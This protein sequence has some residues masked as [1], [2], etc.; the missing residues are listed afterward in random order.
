MS[1]TQA[2]FTRFAGH[3]E[4]LDR[5]VSNGAELDTGKITAREV[6][7]W[8]MPNSFLGAIEAAWLKLQRAPRAQLIGT[9]LSLPEQWEDGSEPSSLERML[10]AILNATVQPVDIGPGIPRFARS[11]RDIDVCAKADLRFARLLHAMREPKKAAGE[12]DYQIIVGEEGVVGL[13]KSDTIAST[14]LLA[15][16]AICGT[17][18]TPAI[19]TGAGTLVAA[20]TT[21]DRKL[22]HG[23]I[24]HRVPR[25]QT[26]VQVHDITEMAAI[27]PSFLSVPPADR[28][29]VFGDTFS[30][31]KIRSLGPEAQEV[32]AT[33]AID[34]ARDIVTNA[35]RMSAQAAP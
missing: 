34:E 18:G 30:K 16:S 24:M 6:S 22:P 5:A 2:A 9:P 14:L 15:E 28:G 31:I 29:E 7:F 21:T 19:V 12:H 27:R 35:A 32:V 11:T 25:G 13:R 10:A 17:T 33:M 26:I 23:Y 4:G 3:C 8:P 1:Y 20:C